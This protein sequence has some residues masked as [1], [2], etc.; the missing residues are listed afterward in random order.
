MNRNYAQ[1]FK[2]FENKVKYFFYEKGYKSADVLSSILD[3]KNFNFSLFNN[4][5]LNLNNLDKNRLYFVTFITVTD[6]KN[7]IHNICCGYSS[8]LEVSLSACSELFE[9]LKNKD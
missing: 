9:S 3:P 6:Y 2:E 5:D 4:V 7:Q 1:D 8:S